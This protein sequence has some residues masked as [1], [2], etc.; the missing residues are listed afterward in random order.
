MK[1]N[2]NELTIEEIKQNGAYC[3]LNEFIL[4]PV[5]WPRVPDIDSKELYNS[6]TCIVAELT[7]DVLLLHQMNVCLLNHWLKDYKGTFS[8]KKILINFVYAYNK[9][10]RPPENWKEKY[11]H[12]I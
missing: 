2:S 5:T 11:F 12:N 8:K 4:L 7:F 6:Y 9:F 1:I 10:S 3:I